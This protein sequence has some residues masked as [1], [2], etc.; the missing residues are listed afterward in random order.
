MDHVPGF[1]ENAQSALPDDAM[2]PIRLITRTNDLVAVS[3][4][5][6]E[7]APD[8]AIA[9]RKGHRRRNHVGPISHRRPICQGLIE[10]PRNVGTNRGG[11]CWGANITLIIKGAKTRPIRGESV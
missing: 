9:A 7:S 4:D 3:G 2:Q 6:P 1:R 10:S 5:D 11:N 8:F